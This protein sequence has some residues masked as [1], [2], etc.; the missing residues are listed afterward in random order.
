MKAVKPIWYFKKSILMRLLKNSSINRR[1]LVFFGFILSVDLLFNTACEKDRQKS[2]PNVVLIMADDLGYSDIACYGGEIQT[3]NL[4]S[5]ARDGIRFSQFYNAA[6]CCPSRA[7]LLSGHYPHKVGMGHMTIDYGYPGYRGDISI[8]TP[9]IAEFLKKSGYNTYMTGKWH[10]TKNAKPNDPHQNRPIQRGFDHFYGTLPGYGS[11]WNPSGLMK[12]SSFIRAPSDYY[13]TDAISKYACKYIEDADSDKEPFF[14]YVA[15][16]APHYPLHAPPQTIDKYEGIYDIGWDRLRKKRYERMVQ[17]GLINPGWELSSRDT[18]SL[19]WKKVKNK[20]WQA[21]R[22]QAYAA[23]IDEM[24][25]GIGKILKT[26]NKSGERD[27]TLVIFL[28]DNGASAEGHLY[29]KI[30][31]L[32][33]PWESWLIPDTNRNGKKVHAGDF[34][35]IPPGADTTFGSYGLK[36]AN[37]S[38]TPFRLFKSWVH[39]GGISTPFIVSWPSNIEETN[40]IS[41][42]VGHIIDLMPTILDACKVEYPSDFKGREITPIPGK[43]LLPALKGEKLK[44]RTLYWE[45]EGNKA[46]RKGKWKLVMQNPGEWDRKDKNIGEWKL[47]NMKEDR[48]ETKNL[49]D[50]YPKIVDELIDEWNK[51]AERSNVVSWDKIAQ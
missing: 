1:F 25:R 5:L 44:E 21:D 43:S 16:T 48:T 35:G 7:A 38:N 10:V 12:D 51:W 30:E 47:Y 49:S 36:W 9:T 29:G 19:P 28:S 46:I 41:H 15:Y 4:D 27:N 3:P 32:G 17:M 40:T 13:Y 37:L 45:H 42:Q 18:M 34:P 23:M 24:D 20:A 2:K 33:I 8:N 26:L 39:E 31:R 14:L 6:R 50:S 11:Y 22:M